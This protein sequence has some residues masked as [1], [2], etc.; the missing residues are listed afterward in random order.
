MP[1]SITLYA[2]MLSVVMLSVVMLS[3]VTLN[4]VAPLNYQPRLS[5]VVLA[6]TCFYFNYCVK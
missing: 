1:L 2:I 5:L 4:V 3:V 6:E